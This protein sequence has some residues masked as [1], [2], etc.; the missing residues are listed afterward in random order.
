[1]LS[2][3]EAEAADLPALVDL[4]ADDPLG[5]QREDNRRP[6]AK[7]YI[8]AFSAIQQDA[9]QHLI[10]AIRDA[11]IVGLLQLTFI[12]GLT[13]KGTWRAQIEGVRVRAGQR[14]QGTGKALFEHAIAQ[15]K[16]QHCKLLQLTSDN[17]RPDAHGFYEALGFV[18]SH[19]G[20]KLKLT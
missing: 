17:T 19:T 20:F 18:G 4:L 14:G 13:H 6:L 7:P 12:P 3:R 1:M 11:E 9:N 2:F 16:A 10:V 5:A 8:K 15:A